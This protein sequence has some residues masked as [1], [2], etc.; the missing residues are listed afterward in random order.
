MATGK[1]ERRKNENKTTTLP[2]VCAKCVVG[3]LDQQSASTAT[4]ALTEHKHFH[5]YHF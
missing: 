5:R 4:N 2:Y 1:K 3:Y